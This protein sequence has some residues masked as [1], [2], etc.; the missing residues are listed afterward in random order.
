M[1]EIDPIDVRFPL[2]I[3]IDSL[4]EKFRDLLTFTVNEVKLC[5]WLITKDID[6]L[7]FA[8]RNEIEEVETADDG[9]QILNELGDVFR[10]TLLLL[11]IA[12]Q[13]GI[14]KSEDALDTVLGKI[15]LRKPWVLSRDNVS[16]D[17]ALE[18]WKDAKRKEGNQARGNKYQ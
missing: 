4:V 3:D 8:L 1:E 17:K 14:V 11:I 16:Y 12:Q 9:E 13:R 6:F 15:R 10:N 18:I 2:T 5:P 7:L